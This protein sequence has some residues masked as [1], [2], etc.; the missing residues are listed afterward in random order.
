[1]LE[2]ELGV[3]LFV[4]RSRGVTLT[5]AGALLLR[6][7]EHVLRTVEQLKAEVGDLNGEPRGTIRIGCTPGLTAPLVSEALRSF[8][9]RC[10][11][12]KVHLQE[13]TSEALHKL[14]LAE[15]LELAVLSEREPHPEIESTHLFDEPIYLF[16]PPFALHADEKVDLKDI[17]GLR[18]ILARRSLTTREAIERLLS[19]AGVSSSIIMETDSIGA[20]AHLVQSGLGFTVAP[21]LSLQERAGQGLMS[22]AQIR[23]F[24][25]RRVIIRRRDTWVT[26]GLQSFMDLVV[27]AADHNNGLTSWRLSP[28]MKR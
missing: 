26:R 28:S 6:R 2:R 3:L 8:M 22:Y 20:I 18:L 7:S 1:M 9:S 19:S 4:R 13:H 5:E 10:P 25:I 16:G 15:D 24:S 11:N 14:V 17:G 21:F 12:V 23:D 27:A